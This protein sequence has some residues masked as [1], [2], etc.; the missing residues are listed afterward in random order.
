VR[1]DSLKLFKI[2]TLSAVLARGQAPWKPIDPLFEVPA[3][4]LLIKRPLKPKEVYAEIGVNFTV[5]G[6]GKIAGFGNANPKEMS[7]FRQPHRNTFHGTCLLV[8]RRVSG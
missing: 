4:G 7:S 1:V 3:L 5:F 8:V 2:S 6:A